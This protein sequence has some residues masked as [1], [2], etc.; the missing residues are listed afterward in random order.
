L[1]RLGKWAYEA[2]SVL[3]G[4]DP[5]KGSETCY[6]SR[7]DFGEGDHQEYVES[8]YGEILLIGG[9]AIVLVGAFVVSLF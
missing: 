8:G 9:A 4:G 1:P 5:C 6:R 2:R 7:D 3:Q